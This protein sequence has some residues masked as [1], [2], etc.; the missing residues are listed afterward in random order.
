[1]DFQNLYMVLKNYSILKIAAH[2]LQ[3]KY[4]GYS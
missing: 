1:M 3:R 2:V 4:N